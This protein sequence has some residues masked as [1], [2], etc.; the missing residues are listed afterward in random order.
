MDVHDFEC[1]T[2]YLDRLLDHCPFCGCDAYFALNK[3]IDESTIHIWCNG[4][5]VRTEA[6]SLS[7][8]GISELVDLWNKRVEQ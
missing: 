4:C 3:S 2:H 6:R 1:I 5:G 8:S 7:G